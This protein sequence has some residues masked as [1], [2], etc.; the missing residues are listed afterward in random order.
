MSAADSVLASIFSGCVG[1]I[2]IRPLPPGRYPARFFSS[3]SVHDAERYAYSLDGKADVYFG[4]GTRRCDSGTKDDVQEIPALWADCDTPEAVAK[5]PTFRLPP[6]IEIETSP[7]R[8]QL[9]WLLKEPL[10]LEHAGTIVSVERVLRG[11]AHILGSDPSVAE[12]ARIMRV[13]GTKNVKRGARCCLLRDDGPRYDL[14]DFIAAGIYHESETTPAGNNG[15]SDQDAIS[16]GHRNTTLASFAGT[17]R[18][19]GMSK[20][21]IEAALLE[22]NV[23]RCTPPLP[24]AEVRGISMSIARY[25]PA[26][27]R[28]PREGD[29]APVE[30]WPHPPAAA[31]YHGVLGEIVRVIEPHTEADPVAVLAQALVGFGSLVGGA[32]HFRVEATEHRVHEFLALVGRTAGGRKGTSWDQARRVLAA[33][34]QEWAEKRIMGGLSSGEGLI[35]EVRDGR[36]EQQARREKNKPTTYEIV[37]VD[38]GVADKRLLVYEPELARVLKV[39]MREGSTLSTTIRQAWDGPLLRVIARTTGAVAT[40]AHV[41]IV[42]H[43]TAEELLRQLQDTEA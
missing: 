23:Q 27:E 42:S 43:I 40:G 3:S 24:E 8:R 22:E 29:D 16:E 9:W 39:A 13:P 14:D 30:N 11:I 10:L 36:E 5:V 15:H 38:P 25:A 33:V 18:R 35:H 17:M 1:K 7:G 12:V 21:A 37:E 19:R 34:D 28:A 6:T 26:D 4:A 32:P 2:E 20:P 31:A 41:S